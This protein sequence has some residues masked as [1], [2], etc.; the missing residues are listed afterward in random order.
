MKINLAWM[1]F[2]V[3]A[4]NLNVKSENVLHTLTGL[5]SVLDKPGSFLFFD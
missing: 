5:S 2:K 3:P 1:L 4:L